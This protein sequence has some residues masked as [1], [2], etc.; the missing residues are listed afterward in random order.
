LKIFKSITFKNSDTL[1]NSNLIVSKFRE[2][3]F[4]S[5]RT[6]YYANCAPCHSQ[7]RVLSG[8]ILDN[9]LLES[10]NIDWLTTFFLDRNKI[11]IDSLYKERNKGFEDISCIE[12]P[13]YTKIDIEQVIE[14]LKYQ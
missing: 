11:K 5:G 12:L 6:I 10:R 4:G 13:N 3:P 2:Y 1:K 14:Y 9:K 7:D 8:P